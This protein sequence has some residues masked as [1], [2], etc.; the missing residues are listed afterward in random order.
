MPC[1]APLHTAG[2]DLRPAWPGPPPP[3]CGVKATNRRCAARCTRFAP[4]RRPA[5]PKLHGL[6]TLG[7]CRVPLGER[8]FSTT[9]R[10]EPAALPSPQGFWQPH[11]GFRC[12]LLDPATRG[13]L[14]LGAAEASWTMRCLAMSW[15]LHQG[16]AV[17]IAVSWYA[18]LG[19]PVHTAGAGVGLAWRG[20]PPAWCVVKIKNRRC[21][22]RFI[23]C[24]PLRRPAQVKNPRLRYLRYLSGGLSANTFPPRHP[25]WS[26]LA[27]RVLRGSDSP[28]Q[29]SAASC[30]ALPGSVSCCWALLSRP[31]PCDALPC[32]AG[33]IRALLSVVL[34]PG[35]PCLFL[36]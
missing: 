3:G 13:S 36:L 21:A 18:L 25:A 14:V 35:M 16:P 31:G 9:P 11:A 33:S 20:P 34:Y 22:A 27:C 17:L 5:P 2:A 6:G 23:R 32:R 12:I 29:G 8:L 30:W 19:P 10:S 15:W 26:Q 4:L 28:M 1:L 7:T 24:A